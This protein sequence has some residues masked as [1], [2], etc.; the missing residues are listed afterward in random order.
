MKMIKYIFELVE[1]LTCS[2]AEYLANTY[3]NHMYLPHIKMQLER[4]DLWN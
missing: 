3:V 2:Q 4:F 1:K